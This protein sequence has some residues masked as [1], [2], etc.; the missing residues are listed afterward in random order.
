MRHPDRLERRRQV[1]DAA[2]DLGPHAAAQGSIRFEGREI[3]ETAAAGDR[4]DGRLA[5][6]GGT[7]VFPRMTV[8]ENLDMGAY[9]RKDKDGI[10]RTSSACSRCSRA[11]KERERQKG[12]HDVRRRAADA[13]DR[14]RADGAAAACCCST[15]RR[16]GSRRSSSSGSTTR[17][18][19]STGRA[20]PILLVEQNANFALGVSQRGY[21]LETGGRALRT[22]PRPCGEPR[23][24]EGVPG[25]PQATE[26]SGGSPSAAWGTPKRH[27][28]TMLLAGASSRSS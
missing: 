26:Q 6:A 18:P 5:L 27:W 4:L 3:S 14:P 12:G 25:A 8:R 21:V 7:H 22:S 2:L 16:W 10:A 15:S 20:R 11:C 24:P 1:H 23:G 19:R 9:L 28:Q 17:S 13:R